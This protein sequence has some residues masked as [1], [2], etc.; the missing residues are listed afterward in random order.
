MT[1]TELLDFIGKTSKYD[2]MD[3][4]AAQTL[5]K[6]QDKTHKNSLAGQVIADMF[7]KSGLVDI[8]AE[9]TRAKAVTSLG[10]I[11]L[12]FMKDD[13]P[14]DGFRMVEDIVHKIDSAFNEEA[15][16]LKAQG[17]PV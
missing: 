2:I 16:R 12:F 1:F 4:N 9:I 13:A 15:L 6:A 5:A 14:A 8:N 17:K 3:G 10:P 11:R 7:T